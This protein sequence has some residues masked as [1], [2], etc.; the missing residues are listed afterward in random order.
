MHPTLYV[1]HASNSFESSAKLH[2][3]YIATDTGKPPYGN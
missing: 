2:N 3:H 1:A